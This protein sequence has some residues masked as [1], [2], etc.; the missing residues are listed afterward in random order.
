[1]DFTNCQRCAMAMNHPSQTRRESG[2]DPGRLGPGRRCLPGNRSFAVSLI[3]MIVI[4]VIGFTTVRV[5]A[6]VLVSE[7]SGADSRRRRTRG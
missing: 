5:V 7:M 2:L 1:M 4:A 6:R 3:I